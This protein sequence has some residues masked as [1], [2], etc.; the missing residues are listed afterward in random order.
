MTMTDIKERAEKLGIKIG[1]MNKTDVIRAIQ[2]K[3]GNFPCFATAKDY[4][5]QLACAWRNACLPTKKLKKDYD[6]KKEL[7]LKKITTEMEELTDKLADLKAKSQKN[8]G[9]GKKEA[10]EE[11]RKIEKKSEELRKKAR[12]L[13]AAGEDAWEIT[14]KG[15]DKAWDEV[16]K[17]FKKALAQFD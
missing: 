15:I 16:R 2:R 10:L 12:K 17:S 7:Y 8:M 4:C 9:E 11:L 14:R 6:Q 13:A 3:E 5:D 1:K